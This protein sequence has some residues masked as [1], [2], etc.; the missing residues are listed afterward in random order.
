MKKIAVVGWDSSLNNMGDKILIDTVRYL[1]DMIED[2]STYR[3]DWIPGPEHKENNKIKAFLRKVLNKVSRGCI[4][5]FGWR[6]GIAGNISY[7][8]RK[9]YFR[10]YLQNYYRDALKKADAVVVA[11]GGALKYETQEHSFLTEVLLEIAKEKSIPVMLNAIGIE[12]YNKNDIRCNKLIKNLNS[13]TVQSVTTRDDFEN[14]R[15]HFVV[16]KDIII[17]KVGDPALWIPE[18]FDIKKYNNGEV[19]GINLIREGIF[20]D[21]KQKNFTIDDEYE[22]YRD[23]IIALTNKGYKWKL[24]CNGIKQDYQFGINLINR[25]GLPHD[26]LEPISQNTKEFVKLI[27]SYKGIIGGRMHASITAYSL[28]VP[29]VAFV[30]GIKL[31]HFSV[32]AKISHLFAEGNE[33]N[34]EKLVGLLEEAMNQ[35]NDKAN[36]KILK[37]ATLSYIKKF[38]ESL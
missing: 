23:I 17:A 6:E 9:C 35:E 1:I 5:I 34:G 36:R 32:A 30:W 29:V 33:I 8:I 14:L 3:V 16:N 4:K 10:I 25:Y 28:D 27:A 37:E 21:Y 18:C 22:L 31:K 38:C 12:Q 13:A 2:C 24:F 15:D 7:L 26:C 19:I 11:G 20:G